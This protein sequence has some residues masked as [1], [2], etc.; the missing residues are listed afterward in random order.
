MININKYAKQIEDKMLVIGPNKINNL[1]NS[2][3]V[4]YKKYIMKN[5]NVYFGEKMRNKLY[6]NVI[7]P[8]LVRIFG[9]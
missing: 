4:S 2:F 6:N 7:N 8:I 5:N 3:Q 9:R 1:P